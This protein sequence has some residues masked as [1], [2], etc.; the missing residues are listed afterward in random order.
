MPLIYFLWIFRQ[1]RGNFGISNWLHTRKC[2]CFMRIF[3]IEIKNTHCGNT[4]N[5]VI[6]I[7]SGC[8]LQKSEL[9]VL[10]SSKFL[11][12]CFSDA[13]T[14]ILYR[15]FRISQ[16][17]ISEWKYISDCLFVRL[18]SDFVRQNENLNIGALT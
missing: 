14:L 7:C 13:K 16:K 6:D 12:H 3:R 15:F 10:F 17:Y 9:I 11:C 8:E 18:H 1:R 5:S 2:A 4:D